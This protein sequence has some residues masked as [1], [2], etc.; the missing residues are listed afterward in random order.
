MS[1]PYP[2]CWPSPSPLPPGG[3]PSQSQEQRQ[4]VPGLCGGITVSSNMCPLTLMHIVA[5]S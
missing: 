5:L 4:P 2:W 1:N 3:L